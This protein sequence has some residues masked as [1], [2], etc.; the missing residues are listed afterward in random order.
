[1]AA[2]LATH[3]IC[4]AADSLINDDKLNLHRLLS[5]SAYVPKWQNE[6]PRKSV[7]CCWKM[8]SEK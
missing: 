4:E 6:L 7:R 1:M 2:Q 5:Q 3:L 8:E